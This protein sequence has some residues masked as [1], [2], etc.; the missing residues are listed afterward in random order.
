MRLDQ[1][2]LPSVVVSL[3]CGSG[4]SP[5]LKALSYSYMFCLHAKAHNLKTPS[6][7]AVSTVCLIMSKG[8]VLIFHKFPS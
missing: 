5:E 6:S 4:L 3:F 1:T 2:L 8:F 7:A